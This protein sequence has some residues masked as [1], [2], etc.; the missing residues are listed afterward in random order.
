VFRIIAGEM[1]GRDQPLILKL[2]E[3]ETAMPALDA[4]AMELDDCN[5]PLLRDLVI[6]DD[7]AV[8]FDGV[9]WA[10]LLG[11]ARRGP[12]MERADLLSMNGGIFREHGRAIAAGAR[13]DVRVVVVGNP[14]NTNCLIARTN[15]PEIPVDRWFAMMRLDQNRAATILAR[16]AGVAND[17]VSNVV[18]WG[19]HSITQ[20]PDARNATI[21]GRPAMDVIA[22]DEWVRTDF[23]RQ[24]ADRGAAIIAARGA[25]SA[26]SAA[27]ALIDTVRSIRTPTPAGQATSLA[28]ASDGEYGVPHGLHFGFPVRSTGD[29]WEIDDRFEVDD[30]AR[31]MIDASADELLRERDT[32]AHLL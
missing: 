8:A 31:R 20:F 28:V 7:P 5:S 19:N 16:K 25:S 3:V 27:T 32:V 18:V 13:D 15:A 4:I 1:F 22:D 17:R 12:G 21:D 6:T 14:C 23:V 9:S 24:V 26:A 10:L 2:L 30:F 29:G 11:A